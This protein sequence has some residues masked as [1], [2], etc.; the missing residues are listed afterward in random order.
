MTETSS[1]ITD[2]ANSAEREH[3]RIALMAL[4]MH[5]FD[6]HLDVPHSITV[7]RFGSAARCMTLSVHRESAEAWASSIAV[8]SDTTEPTNRTDLFGKPTNRRTVVGRLP[9]LGIRVSIRSY[10]TAAPAASQPSLSVVPS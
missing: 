9:D 7:D 1:T 3:E 2:S 10:E 4:A 8:D 6:H 5:V